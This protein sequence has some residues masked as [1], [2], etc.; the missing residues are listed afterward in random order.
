MILTCNA[1]FVSA[2][3]VD[4]NK[5]GYNVGYFVQDGGNPERFI[6]SNEIFDKLTS[7]HMIGDSITLQVEVFRAYRSDK[8]D[9]WRVVDII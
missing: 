1:D 2:R 9:Y 5:G 4:G 3:H 6:I 7:E 8:A